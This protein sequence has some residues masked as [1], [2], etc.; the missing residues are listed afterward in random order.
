MCWSVEMEQII[1]LPQTTKQRFKTPD[2]G[3]LMKHEAGGENEL[4]MPERPESVSKSG[5][6]DAP[7]VW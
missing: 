4:W 3:L 6:E 1:T 7:P 2:S 5:Q